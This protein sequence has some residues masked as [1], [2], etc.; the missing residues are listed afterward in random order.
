MY[1][2]ASYQKPGDKA[3]LISPINP[4][5]PGSCLEFWYHMKGAQMGT[6]S[7]YLKINNK[8]QTVPLWS[9]SGNKGNQWMIASTTIKT[10][11][12]YQVYFRLLH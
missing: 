11:D 2:E 1:T 6:L 9:E 12:S 10:S 8:L 4:T 3:R 5:T 7:V